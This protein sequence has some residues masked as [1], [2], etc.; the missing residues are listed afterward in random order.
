M[1]ALLPPKRFQN[2][3]ANP[4][5]GKNVGT[6]CLIDGFGKALVQDRAPVLVAQSEIQRHQEGVSEVWMVLMEQKM[7]K[8]GLLEPS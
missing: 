1:G 2:Y 7:G 5:R 8:L 6:H 3:P 4:E